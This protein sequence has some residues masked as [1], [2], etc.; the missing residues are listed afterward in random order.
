MSEFFT[1]GFLA[2]FAGAAAGTAAV[3]QF[4]K[5][6]LPK[7]PT[8]VLSYIVSLIILAA[9]TGATGAAEGWEGWAII[10]LNAILVS[11][12]ANGAYSGVVRAQGK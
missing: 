3:T 8:Q 12:A 6:W 4:A 1:W 7:L 10:P 5:G 9:A 2:T 11:L